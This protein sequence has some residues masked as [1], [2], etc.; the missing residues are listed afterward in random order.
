MPSAWTKRGSF[1]V[2]TVTQHKS[3]GGYAAGGLRV[4]RARRARVRRR[5]SKGTA[6]LSCNASEESGERPR[7]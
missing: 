2:S 3:R 5:I 4:V 6:N 1:G 7:I